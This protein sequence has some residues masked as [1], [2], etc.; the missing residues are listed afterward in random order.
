[1]TP[2]HKIESIDEYISA[3]AGELGQRVIEI[4]QPLHTPGISPLPSFDLLGH[5][6]PAQ[7]HAVAAL[8]QM[9]NERGS[10]FFCGEMGVGKTASR[11]PPRFT[12]MLGASRIGPWCCV[13]ITSSTSGAGS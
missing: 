6:F 3:F 2:L 10:G 13:P 12:L 4:L 11:V 8:V 9:L 1:M 5:L 7:Q